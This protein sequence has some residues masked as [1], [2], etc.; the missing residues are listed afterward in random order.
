VKPHDEQGGG[1]LLTLGIAVA[2]LTTTLLAVLWA[3]VSLAAHRA[4]TAADL[5]ALS[6]AE[7]AQSPT[8]ADPCTTADRIATLHHV[9]LTACT[10][11]GATVI[12][13]VT[14]HLHLG[15]VGTPA[16]TAHARAGPTSDI[17]SGLSLPRAPEGADWTDDG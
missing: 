5:T 16:V 12:V 1:T 17:P 8:T 6:A 7:A 13:S 3:T 14:T 11:D 10:V 9:D 15:R 4:T 2:V